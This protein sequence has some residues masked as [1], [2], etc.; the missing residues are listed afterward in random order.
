MTSAL[1]LKDLEKK[2]KM[3]MNEDSTITLA[4]VESG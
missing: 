4:I 1:A 3:E 2:E